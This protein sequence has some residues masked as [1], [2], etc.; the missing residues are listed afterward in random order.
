MKVAKP[1]ED[2]RKA[3]NWKRQKTDAGRLQGH[4]KRPEG[5]FKSG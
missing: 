1:E 3:W 4:Q 5:E 2:A